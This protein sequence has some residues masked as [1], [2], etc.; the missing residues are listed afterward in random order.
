MLARKLGAKYYLYWLQ[1]RFIKLGVNMRRAWRKHVLR[2]PVPSK[3]DASE[4]TA[5]R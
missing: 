1:M 3:R 5:P 4:L 2:Q